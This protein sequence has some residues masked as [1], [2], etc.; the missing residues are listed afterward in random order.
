MTYRLELMWQIKIGWWVERI[1]VFSLWIKF[2]KKKQ[3]VTWNEGVLHYI[4]KS[5]S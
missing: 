5:P 4:N 2:E 3:F 1:S